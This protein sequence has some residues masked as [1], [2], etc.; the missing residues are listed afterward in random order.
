MPRRVFI[1]VAERSAD[2]HAGNL[3]RAMLG[4]DPTLE[5][6]ALGGEALRDAG[7]TVHHDTVSGA[8]MGL[9]AFSRF[10][11]V[12]RLLD[13]TRRFYDAT[14]PDLHICCDSW[15]MN[16]HFARLAKS[17]GTRVMYHIAPQTWASRERRVRELA[18][19]TDAVACILPFEQ[20]YFQRHGVNATYVGHPL[21]DEIRTPSVAHDQN[22]IA[23]PCGSRASVVRA[24]LPRQLEA[25]RQMKQAMPGLR[26]VI[27]TTATTHEQVAQLVAGDSSIEVVR[28]SFD[29]AVAPCALAI[30]VSG[31]ATLHVAALGVP[32]LVVYHGDPLLWHLVGRWLIRTRTF[33]LVNVIALDG[34]DDRSRHVVP[35]YIPWN[36]SVEPVVQHAV[37]LLRDPARLEAQRRALAQVVEKVEAPGAS[38]RAARIAWSL[39]DRGQASSIAP[40]PA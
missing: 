39:L 8:K 26:F 15:T 2:V 38:D 34:A 31:T 19:V 28:E 1:T 40:Q 37:S 16:V 35:E 4:L 14:P 5:I 10:F 24:N 29:Q 3:V 12:R 11:E 20:A 9:G 30:T 7:A 13:W 22:R 23:L 25:A 17:R 21:F 18:R 6:H 27:P 33:A 36:G 32:M